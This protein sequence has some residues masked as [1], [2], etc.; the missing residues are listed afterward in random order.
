MTDLTLADLRA[1]FRELRL[2]G[3]PVIVHASI[4][5]FGPIQGGP[6]T[7]LQAVLESTACMIVPTFTYKTMVTPGVGP[8]NNG[9]TY[10]ADQDANR[11]VIPFRADMPADPLMG[12]FPEMV[13]LHHAARRTSHPILSFAGIHA[14][15][16]LAAQSLSNPLAPIGV[17]AEQDGWVLLLGTDHTVNTS[18]HYAEKLAGRRQFTRWALTPQRVLECVGFPGD[19]GGFEVIATELEQD[20]RCVQV[21]AARVQAVPHIRLFEVVQTR[22]KKN[23]LDLL[24][25]RADC[26]RCGAIRATV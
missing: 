19:S 18:I 11:M 21:G 26:E 9:L 12:F 2:T 4:K 22:L 6:E 25:P 17:L 24:C 14:E 23:P 13:R 1:G 16:A 15:A 5:A 20:S 7:L 10:G 3:C 8:P